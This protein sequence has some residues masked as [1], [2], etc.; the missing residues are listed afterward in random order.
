MLQPN[1]SSFERKKVKI[2]R[3][4]QHPIPAYET[5]YV[6]RTLNRIEK[7]FNGTFSG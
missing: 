5:Q 2:F 6:E 7:N 3:P 1:C 4:N